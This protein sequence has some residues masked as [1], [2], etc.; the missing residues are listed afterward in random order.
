[1]RQLQNCSY[2]AENDE[3]Q[4]VFAYS[5]VLL[6]LSIA[7]Q[8]GTSGGPFQEQNHESCLPVPVELLN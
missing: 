1:M 8:Q 4:P 2:L 3:S 7:Y 6:C 5:S